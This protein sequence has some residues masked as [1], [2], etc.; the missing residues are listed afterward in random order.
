[1]SS[2]GNARP[3][4]PM[5]PPQKNKKPSKLVTLLLSCCLFEAVFSA[6]LLTALILLGKHYIYNNSIKDISIEHNDSKVQHVQLLKRNL[7]L[8]PVKIIKPKYSRLPQE[9]TPIHYD[10]VLKPNFET[11]NITGRVNITIN[12]KQVRA[13]IILNSLNL[14][15]YNVQLLRAHNGFAAPLSSVTPNKKL[16]ILEITS[17]NALRPGKY[18]VIIEYSTRMRDK[19]IGFYESSYTSAEKGCR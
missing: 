6:S 19:I 2:S 8:D 13:N 12:V 18:H 1:M 17:Q 4:R 10:I 11:G 3:I 9:V 5:E 15:I 7:R 16:E 14:V